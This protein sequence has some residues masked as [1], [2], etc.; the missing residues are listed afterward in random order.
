MGRC[1][2]IPS[3]L[4][5]DSQNRNFVELLAL[6]YIVLF[7]VGLDFCFFVCNQTIFLMLILFANVLLSILSFRILRVA[8]AFGRFPILNAFPESNKMCRNMYW[9]AR[10]EF[11]ST[12]LFVPRMYKLLFWLIVIFQS[13]LVCISFYAFAEMSACVMMDKILFASNMLFAFAIIA[14]V[15]MSFVKNEERNLELVRIRDEEKIRMSNLNKMM[16]KY[17][18]Q[19]PYKEVI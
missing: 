6:C 11:G 10:R 9:Y 3:G 15:I 5:C 17:N 2:F 8:F 1:S 18:T 7:V 16:E 14:E 13:T 19:C 12:N 4:H